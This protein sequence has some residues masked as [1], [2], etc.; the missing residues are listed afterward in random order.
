MALRD[1][2]APGGLQVVYENNQLKITWQADSI[3]PGYSVAVQ[4]TDDQDHPLS[5]GPQITFSEAGAIASGAAIVPGLTLKVLARAVSPMAG[6]QAIE[7][8]SL[9]AP[10]LPQLHFGSEGLDIR[11]NQIE[12]ATIYDLEIDDADGNPIIPPPPSTFI[13][14]EEQAHA[15]IGIAD[16]LDKTTYKIRVRAISGGSRSLWSDPATIFIDKTRPASELLQGLLARLTQAG[17]GFDLGPDIVQSCNITGQFASLLSAQGGKLALRD[18]VI[19]TSLD[20]VTLQARIDLFHV[21]G[22]AGTFI[23][24]EEG[25]MIELKLSFPL[26][27]CTIAQLRAANLLPGD[28]FAEMGW[29]DGLAAQNARRTGKSPAAFDWKPPGLRCCHHPERR[30]A[31]SHRCR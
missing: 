4:I 31:R 24:T 8:I 7:L 13:A 29:A 22:G 26:G 1:Y 3:P 2:A 6:P 19:S 30:K 23:F 25:S 27:T 12:R 20:S 10:G 21:V 28:V 16:L 17:S 11:W 9:D 15:R 5:P 18:A 14:G